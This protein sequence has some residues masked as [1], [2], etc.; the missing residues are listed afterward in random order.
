MTD[1][2]RWID[3]ACMIA[4]PLTKKMD[5]QLLVSVMESGS[6]S[7]LQPEESKEIKK[8]KQLGRKRIKDDDTEDEIDAE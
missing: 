6:W 3:T 4:D 7:V 2:I 8:K 1:F 5:P